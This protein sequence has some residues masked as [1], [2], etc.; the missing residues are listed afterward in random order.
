MFQKYELSEI[1]VGNIDE[2]KLGKTLIDL[3]NN[4]KKELSSKILTYL[5]LI[6]TR[7]CWMEKTPFR[8]GWNIK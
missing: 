7:L 1:A 4:S 5:S 2:S 8:P 3:Q 6:Q